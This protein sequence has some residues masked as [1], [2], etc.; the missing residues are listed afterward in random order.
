MA[1]TREEEAKTLGSEEPRDVADSA[2]LERSADKAI[3]VKVG[4][5]VEKAEVLS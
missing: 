5:G 1:A 4:C 2:R 3:E